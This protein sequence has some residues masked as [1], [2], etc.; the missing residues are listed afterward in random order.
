MRLIKILIG[1]LKYFLNRKPISDG[2]TVKEIQE[3]Y[4]IKYFSFF[5]TFNFARW[6]QDKEENKNLPR[7]SYTFKTTLCGNY[8]VGKTTLTLSAQVRFTFDLSC[9]LIRNCNSGWRVQTSATC[10]DHLRFRK[11]FF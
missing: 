6:L 8:G 1:V 3:R 10:Y 11:L 4:L 7:Y 5:L 9:V 2:V